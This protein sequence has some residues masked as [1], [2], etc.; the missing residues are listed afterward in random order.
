MHDGPASVHLIWL[1][2]LFARIM[3]RSAISKAIYP[4]IVCLVLFVPTGAFGGELA[5]GSI[6]ALT[7]LYVSWLL[8]WLLSER[9]FPAPPT[10]QQKTNLKAVASIKGGGLPLNSQPRFEFATPRWIESI[11]NAF[12]RN[13]FAL[14]FA[15]LLWLGW[16]QL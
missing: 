7:L 8:G 12:Y 9:L 13:I 5:R 2:E 14:L 11:S 10:D 3:R 4:S 6:L 1:Y 16:H 15:L